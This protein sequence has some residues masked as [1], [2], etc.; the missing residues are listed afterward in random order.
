MKTIQGEGSSVRKNAVVELKGALFNLNVTNEGKSKK[1]VY[2]SLVD[3]AKRV[4]R[5]KGV[6]LKSRAVSVVKKS[7]LELEFVQTQGGKGS[8][9]RFFLNEFSSSDASAFGVFNSLGAIKIDLESRE[10]ATVIRDIFKKIGNKELIHVYDKLRS[11][12]NLRAGMYYFSEHEN[13]FSSKAKEELKRMANSLDQLEQYVA[14]ECGRR[15][16]VT[17][18]VTSPRAHKLSSISDQSRITLVNLLSMLDSKVEKAEVTESSKRN[19]K[20]RKAYSGSA[21]PTGFARDLSEEMNVFTQGV[22]GVN[23]FPHNPLEGSVHIEPKELTQS[24]RKIIKGAVNELSENGFNAERLLKSVYGFSANSGSAGEVKKEISAKLTKCTSEDLLSI[25][26]ALISDKSINL[27]SLLMI[28]QKSWEKVDPRESDGKITNDLGVISGVINYMELYC[29]KLLLV[30]DASIPEK[31]RVYDRI[32]TVQDI[33]KTNID[34]IRSFAVW[35]RCYTDLQNE[36][37][38]HESRT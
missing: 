2:T 29:Y 33:D 31:D 25:Y 4:F 36:S 23:V 13:E 26:K 9:V 6:Q 1:R 27:R 28:L 30:R 12:D 10:G 3:E 18:E 37:I 35:R 7:A 5:T 24:T 8:G 20:S 34:A 32:Q 38:A 17:Y 14:D 11:I 15:G 21:T 19:D 22:L 16:Y